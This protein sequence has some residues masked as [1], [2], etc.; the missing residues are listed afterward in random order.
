MNEEL[1]SQLKAITV[2]ACLALMFLKGDKATEK[3]ATIDEALRSVRLMANTERRQ[4]VATALSQ[5]NFTQPIETLLKEIKAQREQFTNIKSV[6]IH[7]IAIEAVLQRLYQARQKQ[8]RH[9]SREPR[10]Y[11]Q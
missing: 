2:F 7:S 9:V 10:E 3:D 5:I 11:L 6:S 4:V 8:E 1:F